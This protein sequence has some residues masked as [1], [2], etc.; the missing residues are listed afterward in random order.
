MGSHQ[1]RQIVFLGQS[2]GGCDLHQGQS[3]LQLGGNSGFLHIENS[4]SLLQQIGLAHVC[5]TAAA[6]AEIA[7]AEAGFP[8]PAGT[9]L[10]GGIGNGGGGGGIAGGC[11]KNLIMYQTCPADE[12]CCCQYT[13]DD[14]FV[15]GFLHNH[16]HPFQRR[17]VFPLQNKAATLNPTEHPLNVLL[18]SWLPSGYPPKMKGG[19]EIGVSA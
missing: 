13:G 1:L 18:K 4:C 10:T 8:M 11:G 12:N 9:V 5:Q 2:G 19:S 6:F 15:C 17:F 16:I 3:L 7:A 14:G